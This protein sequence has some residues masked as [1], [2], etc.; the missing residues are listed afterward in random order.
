[1][2]Y[3]SLNKV[4]TEVQPQVALS[5]FKAKFVLIVPDRLIIFLKGCRIGK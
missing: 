5:N 2:G 4:V 3:F 1:M